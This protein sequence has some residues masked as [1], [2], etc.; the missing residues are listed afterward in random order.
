VPSARPSALNRM[1]DSRVYLIG[2]T[3]GG[4]G[5][6]GERLISAG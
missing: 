1:E 3:G 2:T 5:S 4:I 6:V